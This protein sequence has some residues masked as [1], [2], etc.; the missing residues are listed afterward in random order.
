MNTLG[1]RIL[2]VCLDIFMVKACCHAL[3]R[4]H[5]FVQRCKKFYRIG[6]STVKVLNKSS[7]GGLEIEPWS[8]N[9][10]LSI[11]VDESPLGAHMIIWYHWTRYVMYVLDLCV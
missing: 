1:R 10:S 4:V 5:K 2:T 8:D 3:G 7:H 6:P 11:S 9:R